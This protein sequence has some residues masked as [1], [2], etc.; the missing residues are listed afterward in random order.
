MIIIVFID[1]STYDVTDDIHGAQPIFK[2]VSVPILLKKF[3]HTTGHAFY[4]YGT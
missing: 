4:T 3:A 1:N 2:L